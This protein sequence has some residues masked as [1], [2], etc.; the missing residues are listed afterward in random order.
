MK[1]IAVFKISDEKAV[2]L[3]NE[4]LSKYPPEN[5]GF[6]NE[7]IVINYDDQT[8]PD[9]YKAE[10]LRGLTVSN[11]KGLMTT[12]ISILVGKLDLEN[13][14]KELEETQTIVADI[15]STGI[16]TL[17]KKTK[18]IYDLNKDRNDKIDAYEAKA[19]AFEQRITNIS[20]S[21]AG[22]EKTTQNFKDKNAVLEAKIIS[23]VV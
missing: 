20:Q 11:L 2:V 3:A 9:S 7:Y 8:F 12:D 17:G 18:E 22:L 10:E 21:I 13:T 1:K 6:T 19:K 15:K 23:L 5:V 4:H 16:K 14:K